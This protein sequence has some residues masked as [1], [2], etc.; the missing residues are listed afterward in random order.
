LKCWRT[1]WF[2]P[3]IQHT[4]R[5]PRWP[6]PEKNTLRDAIL[7]A[8][9]DHGNK[10]YE[11]DIEVSGTILLESSLPNLSGDISAID[12][13]GRHKTSIQ[14]DASAA[15]FHILTVDAGETTT[16]S[17]LQIGLG[18]AGSANGGAFD[19]FGNLTLTGCFLFFN[20]A[21][22]GG[23]VAN[24]AGASLTVSGTG[25]FV[26]MAS[27]SGGDG[28]A[29]WNDGALTVQASSSFNGNS[30]SSFGGAI[31]N[32]TTATV[33]QASLGR[34]QISLDQR[35]GRTGDVDVIE[36]ASGLVREGFHPEGRYPQDEL[37]HLDDEMLDTPFV[38]RD[39]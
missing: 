24:E 32:L 10:I 8:D 22:S 33:T 39:E 29:I 34:I 16:L 14:R 15:P 20:A 36:D 2:C 18:N 26:N 30:A 25:F 4:S 5:S 21:N 23:A 12:D 6:T 13:L 11:I 7:Q 9:K 1:A 17:G 27:G 35:P 19:N 3:A 37:F 31:E 28:G 38:E